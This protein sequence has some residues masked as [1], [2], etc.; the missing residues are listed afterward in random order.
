MNRYA[1]AR[2]IGARAL[3]LSQG[4]PK[5]VRTKELDP[6]TIAIREYESKKLFINVENA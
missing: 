4:A 6:V 2:I 3:Q 5:L 1:K